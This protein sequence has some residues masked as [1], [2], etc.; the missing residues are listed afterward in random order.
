MPVQLPHRA[1]CQVLLGS[2]NV[3]ACRQVR[4][5]L[6]ADPA[7]FE[8]AR[9]G[10]AE[11]PLQIGHDAIVRALLAQIVL[12]LDVNVVVGATYAGHSDWMSVTHNRTATSERTRSERV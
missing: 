1:L 9:L 3:A 7:S 4:D 6:L 8:D 2:S 11:A 5:D 10:V 12:V